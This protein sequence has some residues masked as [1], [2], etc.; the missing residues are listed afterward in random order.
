MPNTTT[1]RP[2]YLV[3]PWCGLCLPCAR[4]FGVDARRDPR[5]SEPCECCHVPAMPES[6][7]AEVHER[8][9]IFGS[10]DGLVATF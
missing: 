9:F 1:P 4:K 10:V 5:S 3:N 8:D 2:V 6:K 7:S